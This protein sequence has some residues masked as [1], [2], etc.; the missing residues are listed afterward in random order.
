MPEEGKASVIKWKLTSPPPVPISLFQG[1][2]GNEI[3]AGGLRP[4]VTDGPDLPGLP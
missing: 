2:I 3:L 4:E 1:G